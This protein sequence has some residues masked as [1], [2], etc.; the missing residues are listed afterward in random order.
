MQAW[1]SLKS[2]FSSNHY[3]MIVPDYRC[4]GKYIEEKVMLKYNKY[5]WPHRQWNQFKVNVWSKTIRNKRFFLDVAFN[6]RSICSRITATFGSCLPPSQC[7]RCH[8]VKAFCLLITSLLLHTY[9]V[10]FGTFITQRNSNKW[11][12]HRWWQWT[13]LGALVWRDH[14][15]HQR[16]SRSPTPSTTSTPGDLSPA[17]EPQQ[18]E[19]KWERQHFSWT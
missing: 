4:N 14:F 3:S 16:Q 15:A 19:P 18:A 1:D 6:R 17:E 5:D 9:L 2:L 13:H 8:K 7:H 12:V 10:G 11:F